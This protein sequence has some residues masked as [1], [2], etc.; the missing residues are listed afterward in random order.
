VQVT[1]VRMSIVNGNRVLTVNENGRTT[2]ITE[3]EDGISMSVTGE[4][5]GERV[6]E[7]F[8]APTVEA[9]KQENPDAYA[10]YEQITG[11]IGG[12]G[13]GFLQQRGGGVIR[14]NGGALQLGGGIQVMPAPI[15]PD[16]LDQLRVRLEKQ[17]R[18][19]KLADAKHDEVIQ[20]LEKVADA[21]AAAGLDMEKYT[22]QCDE[23]RKVL[24]AHKLDAG[25]LLPPPAKTRLGVSIATNGVTLIVQRIAEK[26]RA[27]RIG[28]QAGDEIRKVNGKDVGTVA[29]LRVLVAAKEKGL[30]LDI[31]RDGQD[32][33]LEEKEEKK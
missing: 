28:L 1:G 32:M 23:L 18:E 25:E 22:Q 9:L 4:L 8:T 11:G 30:T 27:E 2:R 12:A 20:E 26:S 29:E 13:G 19:N 3:G 6:T 14:L 17:M 10:H 15:V 16:E 33:K 21:R 31:T 7:R 24:E 5:D